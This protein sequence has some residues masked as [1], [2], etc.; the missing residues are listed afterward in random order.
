MEDPESVYLL[1]RE[2]SGDQLTE[3]FFDELIETMEN[4][5]MNEVVEHYINSVFGDQIRANRDEAFQIGRDEGFRDGR[6]EGFRDGR[7]EGFRDGRDEGF[8]DGRDEGFRD[9]LDEGIRE[10]C[11]RLHTG[12]LSNAEISRLLGVDQALLDEWFGT[13]EVK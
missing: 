6:D 8:R 7:D 12:N 1:L 2:F 11:R 4:V 9:G 13:D 3:E 10:S 5:Q